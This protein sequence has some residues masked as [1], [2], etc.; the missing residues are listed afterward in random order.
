MAIG[1]YTNVLQQFYISYFGRPADP[2]GLQ[3]AA[4]ALSNAGAPTTTQGL[5][6]SYATNATVRTLIDNFGNSAESAALYGSVTTPDTITN[7]VTQIYLNVLDRQPDLAGLLYW[8]GEISSGRLIP[9]RVALTILDAA[10]RTPDAQTV[11]NKLAVANNFTTNLD[12]V[13]EI[14]AYS[15]NVAAGLARDMLSNV[16]STTNVTA[17]QPNVLQTIVNI[18]NGAGTAGAFTLTNGTDV[19]SANV[20]NAPQL[21]TPGGND[22]INSLQDEDRLTGTGTNPT[23]NVTLGT[24]NDNGGSIITPVLS[25]IATINAAFT[26]STAGLELDL[27]DST[28]VTTVNVT[29]VS[30]GGATIDN[31]TSTATT[32]SVVNSADKANVSL[33]YRNNQ[34]AG[35]TDAVNLTLDNDN[36]GTLTVGRTNNVVAGDPLNQIDTLTI[37]TVGSSTGIDVLDTRSVD[38]QN[39][40]I[41]AGANLTVL[42][43]S[44]P[45]GIQR[46]GVAGAANVTLGAVGSDA[47]FVLAGGTHTGNLTVNI[48]NADQDGTASFT[49]GFGNDV[50]TSN[51]LL[52]DLFTNAGT[53]TVTVTGDVLT[54]GA[55]TGSISTGD[56]ADTVVV[57]GSLAGTVAGGASVSTGAGNDTV[58]VGVP[59]PK[60]T[61]ANSGI[62]LTANLTIAR[63][64]GTFGEEAVLDTGDGD[65]TVTIT[66]TTAG[67]TGG[68]ADADALGSLITLGAGNDTLNVNLINQEATGTLFA[69]EVNGGTGTNTLSIVATNSV[70]AVVAV[71]ATDPDRVVGFQTLNLTSSQAIDEE[72]AANIKAANAALTV[73]VN[74]GDDDN[75][76]GSTVGAGEVSNSETADFDADINEFTGLT[77]INL[78]N[79][80]GVINATPEEF[81][82]PQRF[83][84]DAATY[85][86]RNLAGTE[87]VTLT[88]VEAITSVANRGLIGA[89]VTDDLIADATLNVSLANDAGAADTIA[90]T[91][92]GAGDVAINDINASNGPGTA[93]DGETENLTL[94]INGPAS[95]SIILADDNFEGALRLQGNT[96]G[97]ITVGAVVAAGSAVNTANAVD[98]STI[99][100][101]LTG[102]VNITVADE[103]NYN[104]TTAG[105]NDVVNLLND[106][107]NVSDTIDLGAGTNRI[108]INNDL[109]GNTNADADE[110]FNNLRNIQE[111][112][113]RGFAANQFTLPGSSPAV[114]EVTLDDDAQTTGIS[115]VI[116][117]LDAGAAEPNVDLDI[118]VDFTN[119]LVIDLAAESSTIDIDNDA[120]VNTVVNV[121]ADQATAALVGDADINFTDA[122]TGTVTLNITTDDDSSQFIGVGGDVDLTVQDGDI[123]VINLIDGTSTAR[124]VAGAATAQ[125]TIS[126][127]LDASYG[128]VGGVLTVNAS[129]INDDDLDANNDGDLL[130]AGDIDDN[131]TVVINAGAA[132]YRVNV[133]GS[134][135]TDQIVGSNFNDTIDGQAGLDIIIG[136]LGADSITGGAGPDFFGYNSAAESNSV[137]TDT[138]TDF[139][140]GSDSLFLALN[141]EV[142]GLPAVVNAS[143]FANV[144]STGL[145]DDSLTGTVGN[146]V[147]GDSFYA[148]G[149]G[150]LAID[151]DGD[152]DITGAN[153]Y[154][155]NIGSA[156]NAGDIRL[157]ITGSNNAGVADTIRG[158]V[159]A[160]TIAAGA[161]NDR[162]VYVGSLTTADVNGY[163]VAGSAAAVGIDADVAKVLS[164]SE[165]LTARAQSE[166]GVNTTGQ[167]PT[168]LGESLD[169]GAGND[170]L[171]V[172]GTANLSLV[173]NGNSLQVEAV[174][175]H[176]NITMTEVQFAALNSFTFNG[177]NAHVLNIID[178]N[179]NG[180]TPVLNIN[181]VNV[182]A[183]STLDFNLI[184][185]AGAVVNATPAY[186]L[187]GSAA[188][189]LAL[190]AGAVADAGTVTV[191][192]PVTVAEAQSLFALDPTINYNIVDNANNVGA[193]IADPAVVQSTTLTVSGG[194][195]T[196]AATRA[197]VADAGFQGASSFSVQDT[198]ANIASIVVPGDAALNASVTGY[199]AEPVDAITLTIA[200]FQNFGNRLSDANDIV[201]ING[202][203]VADTLVF[204]HATTQTPVR[205]S[206]GEESG[207]PDTITVQGGGEV[208]LTF[209]SADVGNTNALDGNNDANEDGGLAVRYQL[210][211]GGGT[212]TGVAHRFEDENITFDGRASGTK[213]DV[214][215]LPSGTA[216]G[217][218]DVVTL[219]SSVGDNVAGTTSDDYIN[220]GA[221]NDTLT[222]GTGFDF[223]VGGA[224]DDLLNVAAAD[225][226]ERT[227]IIG[228]GGEDTVAVAGGVTVGA[229]SA[230]DLGAGIADTVSLATG[231]NIAAVNGGAAITGAEVLT[232]VGAVTLTEAQLEGFGTLN[233][234]GGAD[235]VTL[236]AANGNGQVTGNAAVESFVLNDAFTFT[237]GGAAQ[238]VT[239]NAAQNQTV[240]VT[241]NP[242]GVLNGGAGGTDTLQV[243]GAVIN[244][245]ANAANIS[246]FETLDV[247]GAA[248]ASDVSLTLAQHNGFTTITA[249]GNN[250]NINLTTGGTATGASLINS[251]ILNAGFASF[252]VGSASQDVTGDVANDQF[253]ILDGLTSTN[254]QVLNG[255]AGG[256]DTL[257]LRNGANVSLAAVNE[258]EVLNVVNSVTLSYAQYDAVDGT[259]AGVTGAGATDQI[260]LTSSGN[261][262]D[263]DA[264]IETY[265]L[266][267]GNDTIFADDGDFTGTINISSG[268]ADVID[269]DNNG[270][271]DNVLA[272]VFTG[273]ITVT[274]FT[275]G[276]AAG[277]DDFNLD[278]GNSGGDYITITTLG[279]DLTGGDSN[280]N[281]I[282]E[283]QIGTVSSLTDVNAV[284]TF[285]ADAI[286]DTANVGSIEAAVVLYNLAG[287]AGIYAVSFAGNN[288]DIGN[289]DFT[290]ELVGVVNNV[291]VNNFIASN[292]V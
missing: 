242:T 219:G 264:N 146:R 283:L 144:A 10:T 57:T 115:R 54:N 273:F 50:V 122:G 223:L 206:L 104:I 285:I 49:T 23:L 165:L 262:I 45:G 100:S 287:D 167:F 83:A 46:I 119:N 111:L 37:N 241:A 78:E 159:G 274:G 66:G 207:T 126:L 80:A 204:N 61:D 256:N 28:G 261:D 52:G 212:P 101:T 166:I 290:I 187:T 14:N 210:E 16:D 67:D 116:L 27:Q 62:D 284:R 26:S 5:V 134:Q 289:G 193:A 132:D 124:A 110:S 106:T 129:S 234:V 105:G 235:T 84:G 114:I 138:I 128:P 169:G 135:L 53:D 209:T 201:S 205:V 150:R 280:D 154:V 277:N 140:T 95:R 85:T 291:G 249:T 282:L 173:N 171:D 191:N 186:N 88:T 136:G 239:G 94:T 73:V 174:V 255:G 265:V 68:G 271:I 125:T 35:T 222:G 65:D 246:G 82:V 225:N 147:V 63:A 117:A 121:N 250:D 29:R 22:R 2:I 40:Q 17:F 24:P 156:V 31:L 89:T 245:A 109:R 15:G 196:V 247:G 269:L 270:I 192:G 177:N 251:Y 263:T 4:Q 233:A 231:T 141:S 137:T 145:G 268:G 278:F 98:A 59:A 198:G 77:A 58:T 91:I 229:S 275:A 155:I 188:D 240:V 179:G 21:F 258:F 107:V 292:F 197:I 183:N 39:I 182:G 123:D 230:W 164:Y 266:A 6:T 218:F 36:I 175:G 257:S 162:I 51:G 276:V 148:S 32:L 260:T 190:P 90:V 64:G 131:Q 185:T 92:A 160:D 96:T 149:D 86:V 42:A 75:A 143:G 76:N 168:E 253:V 99:V 214:R 152:G 18:V 108:I 133:T 79:Q 87:A 189:L 211:N 238:N 1:D 244:L 217:V 267:N 157:A 72:L 213:F 48:S 286:D 227:D 153:D 13:A 232:I 200:Q 243:V 228:G 71:D 120:N 248:S 181:V 34:I 102:N 180:T 163:I 237:L 195:T 202:T 194:F 55:V 220:G 281:Q 203:A 33:L 9:S 38:N 19:A 97:T 184:S 221:G 3:S 272:G 69:G 8:S 93:D 172:F 142:G 47:G 161:G 113:I 103:A 216:R 178:S 127:N 12:T 224:G 118:G 170:T 20:F 139:A 199:N 74:D 215:D 60:G 41:N 130:D 7:F 288:G 70:G 56:G 208:R 254:A 44:S 236:T 81:S 11:A 252:T 30:S 226:N 151:V 259:A 176:S 158:G 25:G 43:L 112:E 279:F